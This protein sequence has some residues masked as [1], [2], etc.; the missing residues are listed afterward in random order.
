MSLGTSTSIVHD[1]RARKRQETQTLGTRAVRAKPRPTAQ[2]WP[3][4]P[5]QA[6]PMLP[7]PWPRLWAGGHR[8]PGRRIAPGVREGLHLPAWGYLHTRAKRVNPAPRARRGRVQACLRRRHAGGRAVD[9]VRGRGCRP[10]A[11]GARI[12]GAAAYCCSTEK[13]EVSAP[14]RPP[15]AIVGALEPAIAVVDQG[16]RERD[17]FSIPA[18]VERADVRFR[19]RVAAGW[20]RWRENAVW[21]LGNRPMTVQGGAV[22][23]G[24][25]CGAQDGRGAPPSKL[26]GR[27]G[28]SVAGAPRSWKRSA[29]ARRP[30][31]VGAGGAAR[32]R[33]EPASDA[34]PSP[35]SSASTSLTAVTPPLRGHFGGAPAARLVDVPQKQ[36]CAPHSGHAW[37]PWI[38]ENGRI[39]QCWWSGARGRT[40]GWVSVQA[41]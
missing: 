10:M 38:T 6:Q 22:M 17:V 13:V 23:H 32:T 3:H 20:W 7:K 28:G 18:R 25:A 4:E 2:T 5:P 33:Q 35:A 36:A 8:Q 37:R 19:A 15:A 39:R 26:L 21:R 31:P 12:R 24:R 30:R 16:F 14:S 27:A 40:R 1:E 34:S 11:A 29:T 41:P 9:A